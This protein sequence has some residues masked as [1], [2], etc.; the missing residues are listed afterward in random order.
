MSHFGLCAFGTLGRGAVV[1]F[2]SRF[3]IQVS[4][5]FQAISRRWSILDDQL[6]CKAPLVCQGVQCALTHLPPE[7]ITGEDANMNA[8]SLSAE[9]CCSLLGTQAARVQRKSYSQTER[10]KFKNEKTLD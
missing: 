9:L 7:W 5:A 4:L 8:Q 6:F 1:Q 3:L 10:E 2:W